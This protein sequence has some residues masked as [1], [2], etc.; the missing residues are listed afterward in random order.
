MSNSVTA[1]K[2]LSTQAV[3]PDLDVRDRPEDDD[4]RAADEHDEDQAT[5]DKRGMNDKDGER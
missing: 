4:E 5:A 3:C 1:V 2:A